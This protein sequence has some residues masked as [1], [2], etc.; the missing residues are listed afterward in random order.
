MGT[1]QITIT[2]LPDEVPLRHKDFSRFV[3]F[4]NK[5]SIHFFQ[6][7]GLNSCVFDCCQVFLN[8]YLIS[9]LAV[10]LIVCLLFRHF[11]LCIILLKLLKLLRA[12]LLN[13]VKEHV[14]W[15]SFI[16][17]HP[18]DLRD[19]PLRNFTFR[20]LKF[21]FQPPVNSQQP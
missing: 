9:W 15:N 18:T 21:T 17:L 14:R 7:F 13:F 1:E 16:T 2:Q 10:Y 6:I 3:F 8:Y 5:R 20:I 12:V 11:A 19:S 4:Q